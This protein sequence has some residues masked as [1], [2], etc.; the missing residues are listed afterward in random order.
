[1]VDLEEFDAAD[2]WVVRAE[3]GLGPEA[4]AV[5]WVGRLD[6]KKRVEDVIRAAAAV[7]SRGVTGPRFFIV[8]G[9]DAFMPEYEHELRSLA[10]ALGLDGVLT[11]LGDRPD[12]PRLLAGFD[13]FL[14]LS[15]GEGMPHV[16]AEAGA[17]G[18]PVIA[19]EDNGTLQ[20]IEHG[21]TGLF[22]PH[23]DPSAVADALVRLADDR[24]LRAR[25]G[26][27]LHRKVVATYSAGVVVPRWHALFDEVLADHAL[28]N[29]RAGPAG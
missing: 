7:S 19:T 4:L 9:P 18:L 29:G 22:V 2:R 25:L 26:A 3:L 15:R 6:R 14:W 21:L 16:I 10:T 24:A 27:G 12:V 20:Q 28:S 11:F 13:A 5:G 17:A 1:M 8:G 23:E